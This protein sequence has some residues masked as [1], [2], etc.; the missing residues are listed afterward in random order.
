MSWVIVILKPNQSIKAEENLINQELL[1]FFPKITYSCNG[2]S[3]TKDLFPGYA[4]IEF[5]KSEQLISIDSTKGVSKI[6]RINDYVPQLSDSVI[7]NIKRDLINLNSQLGNR[8]SFKK[9]DIVSIKLKILKQEAQV[10]DI[11]NKKDSQKLLLKILNS[12]QVIWVDGKHV[13]RS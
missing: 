8:R 11:K 5:T 13:Q 1:T 3:I 4:F 9:N 12:S 10:I 7:E 2:K 6:M